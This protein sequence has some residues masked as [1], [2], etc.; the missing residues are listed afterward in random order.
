MSGDVAMRMNKVQKINHVS[1][2]IMNLNRVEGESR[3]VGYTSYQL[4]QWSQLSHSTIYRTLETAVKIGAVSV[5][6]KHHRKMECKF[7]F[8]TPEQ[9]QEFLY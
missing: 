3:A 7:Y 8:L 2:I 5:Q 6:K 9:F 4:A 1:S